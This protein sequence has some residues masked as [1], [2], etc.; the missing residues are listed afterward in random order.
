MRVKPNLTKLNGRT[1]AAYALLAVFLATIAPQ[2][3]AITV[4]VSTDK[5]EYISGNSVSV[6]GTVAS[7]T[8][9][10]AVTVEIK[11]PDGSTWVF[12]QAT[13]SSTGA[14]SLSNVNV[15]TAND[16]EG[17]YTVTATYG[18]GST[19]T[20]TFTIGEP[21]AVT[22]SADKSS[23]NIGDSVSTSGTVSRVIS[24]QQVAIVITKPNG[25]TWAIDTTTPT[26]AGA[27]TASNINT[28]TSSD[29]TGT[30]TISAT[31]SG[32]TSTTTITYT[33]TTTTSS[34]AI[35]SLT[36]TP[37]SVQPNAEYTVTAVISNNVTTTSVTAGGVAL[38]LSSGTTQTGTWTANLLASSTV[39]SYQ[40]SVT[41]VATTGESATKTATLIVNLAT[42]T[43]DNNFGVPG[44]SIT[45]TGNNFI[46]STTVT[47][48]INFQ[49]LS[50]KLAT[51]T[52]DASGSIMG[53][54]RIPSLP[55]GV[56]TLTAADTS[57]ST[58]A[59]IGVGL[60]YLSSL[61]IQIAAPTFVTSGATTT[62]YL[63]TT[64]EGELVDVT[65]TSQQ[66]QSS[67]SS[68]VNIPS[69]T[70]IQTGFYF[71]EFTAPTTIGT[72]GVLVQAEYQN[73]D[74]RTVTANSE[75]AL[76]V[77]NLSTESTTL[78]LSDK[79]SQTDSKLSG[80][81]EGLQGS[82]TSQIKSAQTAIVSAIG[83]SEGSLKAE[84]TDLNSAI[85][86][87]KSSVNDA[88][89][90]IIS[91]LGSINTDDLENKL[92]QIKSSI[93]SSISGV[94]SDV[95]EIGDQV[96]S[97][98]AGVSTSATFAYVVTALAAIVLVLELAILVRRR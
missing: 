47:I 23:Y 62:L 54:L 22:A 20:T 17:T 1:I 68:A 28:F 73:L 38:T 87:V 97:I 10:V 9:G 63:V 98:N 61:S 40:I 14:W 92:D 34:I 24:G 93:S 39:G 60:L 3:L 8:S 21:V 94:E 36:L 88:Q 13:P 53:T 46:P 70:K 55:A 74:G 91:G 7:V 50:V 29:T 51:I 4:T 82:L 12:D 5:T 45:Y 96:T 15:V 75:T 27:W 86:D 56:Y 76:T 30:Y 11:K 83:L 33:G 18:T 31:Y 69:P 80:Q 57:R 58:T 52:S 25:A 72:Y 66:Y 2:A 41:A 49:G 81:I 85:N 44:S 32:I 77:A 59:N 16:A 90:A 79:L 67:S 19:G 89:N 65:F 43:L 42:L 37:S 78:A 6:S 26:S 95:Q 35:T 71:I 48:S 64:Y 84:L